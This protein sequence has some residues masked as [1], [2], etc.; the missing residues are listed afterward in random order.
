RRA[1]RPPRGPAGSTPAPR[2]A[3]RLRPRTAR[4]VRTRTPGGPSLDDIWPGVVTPTGVQTVP[5]PAPPPTAAAEV[6]GSP[7]RRRRDRFGGTSDANSVPE[8]LSRSTN[9]R[10]GV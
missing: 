9:G 4:A 10:T 5:P 1:H 3:P 6:A 8:S 2:V 7:A